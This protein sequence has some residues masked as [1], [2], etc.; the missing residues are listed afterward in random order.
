M[1]DDESCLVEFEEVPDLS[2]DPRLNIPCLPLKDESVASGGNFS[3]LPESSEISRDQETSVPDLITAVFV[4]QF[5]TRRGNDI[6]WKYPES[7]DLI[8]VEFKAL[9]SG[10][11]TITKDFIYFKTTGGLYGLSCYERIAVDNVAERGARMKSVGILCARYTSLHEHMPFLEEEVRR[12]LENPGHYED[13]ENYYHCYKNCVLRNNYIPSP[14]YE[15]APGLEEVPVLKI[16]HPAGCFPQFVKFF[17]EHIF[18]L[19]KFVLLQKRILFFS[20][21]PVGVAC[22]RVYCACLLASHGIPF[23]FETGSNP[24]F[25]TNVCDLSALKDEHKYVACT[26]EKIFENKL[27]VYDVYVDNQNIKCKPHL[28]WIAHFNN[29]DRDRLDELE[30][31]RKQ[32]LYVGGDVTDD[33]KMYTTFFVNL[34]NTVFQTLFEVASTEDR[35]LTPEHIRSIGLDP[36]ADLHFLSDLVDLYGINVLI[37]EPKCCP[38]YS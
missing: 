2:H 3:L 25:F 1:A 14:T 35:T 4:V 22:Y 24:L 9:A 6:E 34:N 17:G 36:K 37:P 20:P 23:G 8:G 7:A 30:T 33:E 38:F 15:K 26:T 21:P 28:R 16:T 10:S 19:W 29:A 12:Q 32:Q 27:E 13:L 5:E 11:H 18:V 31:F